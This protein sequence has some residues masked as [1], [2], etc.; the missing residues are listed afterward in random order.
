MATRYNAVPQEQR[1][2]LDLPA[3]AVALDQAL[4]TVKLRALMVIKILIALQV[5]LIQLRRVQEVMSGTAQAWVRPATWAVTASML[6][7]MVWF[8]RRVRDARQQALES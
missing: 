3:K 2:L 7:L 6:V 5:G 8:L 1:A 4:R